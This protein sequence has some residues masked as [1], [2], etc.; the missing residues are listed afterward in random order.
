VSESAFVRE[1]DQVPAGHAKQLRVRFVDEIPGDAVVL[2][3]FKDPAQR[4]AI[5]DEGSKK[6]PGKAVADPSNETLDIVLLPSPGSPGTAQAAQPADREAPPPLLVKY[7]GVEVTWRPTRATLQCD[8]D[9]AESL[10]SAI[11]EFTHYERELRRIEQEI[12]DAWPELDQDRPLAFEVTPAD[13]VRSQLVGARMDRT[14]RRRMR[15]ARIEPH[16]FEPDPKFP[17]ASQK[18]GEE[19][20]ERSRTEARLETID[21]QLEVFEHIYEMAGQRIG[22]YRAAREEHILEWI[23]IVLLAAE[24]LAMLAQMVLR[25]RS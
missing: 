15:H 14:F 10:L 11:V 20:R 22:E 1:T 9:Q 24:A 3:A 6:T 19:L 12:A 13:L 5:L 7:R 21:G 4:Y 8:P 16:L 25:L 17:A 2:M 18:L 23:I